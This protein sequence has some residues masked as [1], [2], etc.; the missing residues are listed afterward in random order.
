M[1][2]PALFLLLG[3]MPGITLNS[4]TSVIASR[5]LGRRREQLP[6]AWII[7]CAISLVVH[8]TILFCAG[9]REGPVGSFLPGFSGLQVVLVNSPERKRLDRP[10]DPPAQLEASAPP[11]IGRYPKLMKF[12]PLQLPPAAFDESAYRSLSTVTVPPTVAAEVSVT[13]PSDP[14]RRELLVAALTLFIDEDGSVAKVRVEEPRAPASYEKAA[15]DAFSKARFNPGLLGKQAVKTR[16]V[17]RVAFESTAGGA[18]SS[19]GIR[20]RYRSPHDFNA[21]RHNL[22]MGR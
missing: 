18:L 13:Y 1:L 20:F 22:D 21:L 9:N 11:P 6:V 8:A 14:Q 19:A 5:S 2:L 7:C 16:M 15:V 3:A 17:I 10:V 12:S 4:G